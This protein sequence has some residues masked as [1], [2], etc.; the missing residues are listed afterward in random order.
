[1]TAR[2]VDRSRT[3]GA[4]KPGHVEETVR[5]IDELRAEHQRQSTR[6]QRSV[7]G[8]MALVGRPAFAVAITVLFVGWVGA[9]FVAP[10]LGYPPPDPPPFTW[11]QGFAT[12]NL[13]HRKAR[14]AAVRSRV[15]A[16]WHD[17][18]D[19]VLDS[20]SSSRP[21]TGAGCCWPR[22]GLKRC[23]PPLD[24]RG[25]SQGH[26]DRNPALVRLGDKLPA[27]NAEYLAAAEAEATIVAV[28]SARWPL[29]PD[30]LIKPY[31]DKYAMERGLTGEAIN[32]P[33]HRYPL[34]VFSATE[35]QHDIDEIRQDLAE[36]GKLLAV[37]ERHEADKAAVL[38][39][40][41]YALA[42]TRMTA[43]RQALGELVAEIMEQPWATMLGVVVKAQ[44]LRA[45]GNVDL[46]MCWSTP[47]SHRWEG[48]VA[49]SVLRLAGGPTGGKPTSESIV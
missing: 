6:L 35:I 49:A 46:L 27:I 30:A 14:R 2:G 36:R 38:D 7:D 40:S 16:R 21:W 25:R 48:Q 12:A 9:N 23:R 22:S 45:W 15:R 41:S 28:W 34:A 18:C 32:R 42:H 10:S 17:E 19:Y 4:T 37:A 11:M 13:S 33:G 47:E 39:A 26:L 29:A 20:L 31:R 1:M 5:S 43:A 3:E 8:L 24:R 44:A